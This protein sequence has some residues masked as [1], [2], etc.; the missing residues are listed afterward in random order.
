MQYY[1]RLNL[2]SQQLVFYVIA[3]WTIFVIVLLAVFNNI[4]SVQANLVVILIHI[5]ALVIFIFFSEAKPQEAT[6]LVDVFYVKGDEVFKE[7]VS[8]G[9]SKTK[10][11]QCYLKKEIFQMEN[12]FYIAST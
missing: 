4:F 1:K 10:F 6:N 11:V 2:S 5:L 12:L 8:V 3:T 7:R 9:H